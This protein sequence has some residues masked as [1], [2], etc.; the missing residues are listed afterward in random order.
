[1]PN[2]NRKGTHNSKKRS[3]FLDTQRQGV[4]VGN[5]SV[6]TKALKGGGRSQMKHIPRKAM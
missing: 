2:K 6:N 4:N 3:T 5:R 1:M